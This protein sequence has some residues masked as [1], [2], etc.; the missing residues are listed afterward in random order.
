MRSHF[1]QKVCSFPSQ[2]ALCLFF[3]KLLSAKSFL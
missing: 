1:V 3:C 2:A